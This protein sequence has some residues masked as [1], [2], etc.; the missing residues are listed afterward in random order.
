MALIPIVKI[1]D[2]IVKYENKEKAQRLY[3]ETLAGE[4]HRKR[5]KFHY[6]YDKNYIRQWNK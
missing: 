6:E 1:N 4:N 5:R 3:M 2:T